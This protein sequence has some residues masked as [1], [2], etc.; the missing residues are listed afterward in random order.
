MR[1]RLRQSGHGAGALLFR[2]LDRRH[3]AHAAIRLAARSRRWWSWRSRAPVPAAREL[4]VRLA[5]KLMTDETAQSLDPLRA[6]LQLSGDE[7]REGVFAWKGF[8]YYKWMVAEWGA[9]HAGT[10]A[11]HPGRARR[12]RPAR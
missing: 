2:Y 4:S 6:T 11:Q 8:L 3:H 1:E 9:R 5:D 12:Q 7:Y 10:R